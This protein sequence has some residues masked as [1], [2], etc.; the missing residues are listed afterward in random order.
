MSNAELTDI[1][2]QTVTLLTLSEGSE[3]QWVP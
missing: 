2:A 1:Q 3:L